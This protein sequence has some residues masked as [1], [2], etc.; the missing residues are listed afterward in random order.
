MWELEWQEPCLIPLVSVCM[1]FREYVCIPSPSQSLCLALSSGIK[2]N[3]SARGG[4]S[5]LRPLLVARPGCPVPPV[6]EGLHLR[7]ASSSHSMSE[8][9]WMDHLRVNPGL[10]YYG[11]SFSSVGLCLSPV[12]LLYR[13][14]FPNLHTWGRH[15]LGSIQ[16]NQSESWRLEGVRIWKLSRTYPGEKPPSL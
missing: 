2:H 9:R 1:M 3:A 12:N 8:E 10:G 13:E 14:N 11:S 7:I 15:D 5:H 4:F 6:V 16:G